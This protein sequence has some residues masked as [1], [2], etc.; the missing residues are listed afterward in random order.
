[1]MDQQANPE[2][3]TIAYDAKARLSELL[4]RVEKDEQIVITRD[5]K[6]I[7]RL[8]PEGRPE[9]RLGSA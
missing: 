3:S 6:P 5:D 1:M 7:A 4:D 8:V 9:R 2:L